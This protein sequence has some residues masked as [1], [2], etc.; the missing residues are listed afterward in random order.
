MSEEDKNKLNRVEEMKDRLFSQNYDTQ[1]RQPNVFSPIPERPVQDSWTKDEK[2]APVVES[3]FMHSS[4]FKKFFIFSLGFFFIAVSYAAYMF[5]VGGNTVSNNNID[6][7]VQG[8]TFTAGGE[9]LP[10]IIEIT[11]RNNSSLDLVDLIVEYPKSSSGE[12]T[13]D[14]ERLR[15]SLGSIPAG[16]VRNENIKVVL[17]GEQGSLRT[18]R[19]SIEYRVEGSNSIFT[20][21]KTYDVSINSSPIDLTFTAPDKISSNQEMTLGIKAALNSNKVVSGVLLKV[22]YPLGFEFISASPT[23]TLGNNV[24]SLEDLAPGA[25]RE[26]SILGKMVDVSDGEEKTFRVWSGTQAKNDK[27][28]IGVVFNSLSDVVLVEKPSIEARLYVNGSYQREYSAGSKEKVFAE[29][30]WANNLDTSIN[31]LDIRVKLGGNS[32]SRQS[33]TADRGF[34]NSLI[35]TIIW[36]KSSIRE[37]SQVDPGESGSLYFSF[38]PAMVSPTAGPSVAP[39]IYL[40]LAISGRQSIDGFGSNTLSGTESKIIKIS[41]DV[42]FANK[43]LYYSGAFKNTG[44]IPPKVEKETTYTVVW[45]LSNTSNNISKAKVRTTLPAWVRY[46]GSISPKI[47]DVKYN[48]TTKEVVWDVGNLSKGAGV[49]G[50]DREVSFQIGFTPS[51]SQ[52]G[53]S[54]NLIN[55]AV[56]TG[57]DDFANVDVEVTKGALDTRLMNDPSFPPTGDKVEE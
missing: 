39:S 34:Y 55:S 14:T 56:L 35:D 32:L 47:E 5:F 16:A 4:I 6:I 46:V 20:K 48:A 27:S 44:S 25:E 37:F 50:L 40:D 30:R 31:D 8:N 12:A 11:N 36:D 1:I 49:S 3:S 41:S 9:E 28:A 22:D 7:S 26:I 19:I 2:P 45:S 33:I 38:S 10:L 24:W 42:G 52:R 43:I 53:S 18:I 57:H 15:Q 13:Q 17:Y 51:L 21:E 54:P 23:P 29:V